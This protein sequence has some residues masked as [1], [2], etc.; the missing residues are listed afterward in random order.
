M[1]SK[2]L[3]YPAL[4][5]IMAIIV[6]LFQSKNVAKGRIKYNVLSPK[7]MGHNDNFDRIFRVHLNTLE[8]MPI[9]LPL[10]WIF[11]LTIS[12]IYSF[13]LGVAWSIGR[14]AY[15]IGYYKSAEGRHNLIGYLSD[16]ASLILMVGSV[17]G[18]IM[19]LVK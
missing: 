9:F 3:A 7:T 6:F 5:T 2:E 13:G 8:Q 16:L 10:L 1:L 17:I 4:A 12:P 11:A 14:I 15:S 18:S 19:L